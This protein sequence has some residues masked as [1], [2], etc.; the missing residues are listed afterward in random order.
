MTELFRI[1]TDQTLLIWSD[2]LTSETNAETKPAEGRLAIRLLRAGKKTTI[3]RQGLPAEAANNPRV[4]LGPPL[5]EETF[6]DLLLQSKDKQVELRHRDPIV[7]QSLHS[8][9]DKDTVYG[10]LNFKSQIGRSRFSVYVDREREYDFEV[11]VFPTK[12]DYAADYN[13]LMADLQDILTALVLE[14][15]RSTYQLGVITDSEGSSR[16]EWILLLHHVVDDLERALRYIERHPHHDLVRE[17]LPTRVE[18]LRRP[19]ATI[20]KMVLQGKGQ[21]PA[22]KTASGRIV[23]SRLPE[24]RALSTWDIPEHRWLKFQLSRIGETLAEIHLAERKNTSRNRLR[25]LRILEEIARLET[26]IAALETIQPLAQAKGLAPAGFTSPA[27]Q[28]KPGYR[29]ASRAC[30]VLLQ[31]LRV[32]GGP[33]GLSV[34][35]IH[36]L[37]EYWCYLT[38]V[39]LVAKITGEQVPVREL[40]IIKED[41]LRVRLQR[42]TS[43]TVKFSTGGR[44]LELT[45]NPQYDN[46]AL[47]LPQ[48]PDVVLTFHDPNW[49]T[50]RLVLDAKYRVETSSNY[51]KQFGIPGP[52]QEAIDALH[53]YRDAILED[54]G[55]HGS[56]SETVKRSV[57]EG[58]ALYPYADVAN[59]FLDSR[60]WKRLK[61][62]GIGAIPFLP[63]ETLYLQEWLSNFLKQGGWS[64]AEQTIPYPSLEQ[65]HAWQQAEKEAVL[66]AVL[67]VN[68]RE[69]LDWINQERCYYTT[70]TATQR[71]QLK[72]RWVA[73]YSPAS[74]R[75]PGAV[76]HLA[77]VADVDIKKRHEIET[78]WSSRRRSDEMQVVYRLGEIRELET[79]IENRGPSGLGKRFSKNRWTSRLGVIRASEL[80][81]LFLE[82]SAEW[83]LYEQLRLAEAEFKLVPGPARL[84]DESSPRGRT[85]FVNKHV[86]VQYRGAA[87][88]LIR[89]P[90][91]RDE[92]LS[93]LDDVVARF[94]SV[95]S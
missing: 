48:K 24:R 87:G 13:L 43:Q 53:R 84:Q 61:R 91:I 68:A 79:P 36:C 71:R 14:Y 59:E 55:L 77:A 62:I 37:Y 18:K 74:I 30:L 58:V 75:R 15:L 45:Y 52:P 67:K 9:P 85:W 11:E 22:S 54:S 86:R 7:S 40:F 82:T 20:A 17:R 27:L 60:L 41:G 3:W 12:L 31:G 1:E 56:R 25:Q 49:P 39:R 66:I 8:S 50:M 46:D 44:V 32:D 93:D 64:I 33:V 21:G 16:L 83:R 47:I 70:F 73:I 28:A 42:G 5:Y 34:K 88:F 2:R 76:T 78:P 6:Y 90:G 89:R 51:V 94:T 4:E 95:R 63:R 38:L 69:H 57:V 10:S 26:R 80:R 23:R 19:D 29:E 92:Y 72:S 65:S 81:E 35:D